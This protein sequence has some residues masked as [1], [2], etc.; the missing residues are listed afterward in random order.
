MTLQTY[1]GLPFKSH[2][3][4][5]KEGVDCIGLVLLVLK[6]EFDTV[7]PDRWKYDTPDDKKVAANFVAEMA[8]SDTGLSGWKPCGPEAGAV[9]LFEVRGAVRHIGIMV[10]NERFL[11][12]MKNTLSCIE[13]VDSPLWEKRIKGYYKWSC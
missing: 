10:D 11:H 5:L 13:R 9:V 4:T 2:G 3:R 6:G 1:M 12:I 8:A 7:V